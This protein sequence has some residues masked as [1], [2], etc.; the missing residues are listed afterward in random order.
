M[1]RDTQGKLYNYYP[2]LFRNFLLI[3]ENELSHANMCT[4]VSQYITISKTCEQ[5]KL[6]QHLKL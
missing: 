4:I 6:T 2:V 5:Y 1:P 3:Y